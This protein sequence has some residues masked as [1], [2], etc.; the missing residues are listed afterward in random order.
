MVKQHTGI[1]KSFPLQLQLYSNK[2]C[3]KVTFIIHT[4]VYRVTLPNYRIS[5]KKFDSSS[6][7]FSIL[8]FFSI[9]PLHQSKS[10]PKSE[11]EVLL[12]WQSLCLPLMNDSENSSSACLTPQESLSNW[13]GIPGRENHRNWVPV[14]PTCI[15]TLTSTQNKDPTHLNVCDLCFLQVSGLTRGIMSKP[16]TNVKALQV[17]VCFFPSV[18]TVRWM[19]LQKVVCYLLHDI[20]FTKVKAE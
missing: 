13:N 4:A 5:K 9:L 15:H 8:P 11:I 18:C 1:L 20:N 16:S 19:C 2:N 17:K 7:N 6:R 12:Y 10:H 3:T 14:P